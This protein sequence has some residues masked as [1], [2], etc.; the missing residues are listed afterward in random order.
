MPLSIS[1]NCYFRYLMLRISI[2]NSCLSFF[3]YNGHFGTINGFRLGRLPNHPVDWT[4]INAAWGQTALLLFS[5][6]RKI[7]LTFVRYRVVPFGNHSFVETL[8][9][10][11]VKELPL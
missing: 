6:A 7:N 8:E 11:K 2:T 1:G 10:S 5:L 4:E 3:R 9:D